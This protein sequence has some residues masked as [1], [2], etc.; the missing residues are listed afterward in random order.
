MSSGECLP[1]PGKPKAVTRTW[2]VIAPCSPLSP[3]DISPVSTA[4]SKLKTASLLDLDPDDFMAGLVDAGLEDD[5]SDGNE[6]EH[7]DDD[8]D[9]EKGEDQGNDSA[10][11]R[12]SLVLV[13]AKRM[14][15][16]T[17]VDKIFSA[18]VSFS[19]TAGPVSH[20]NPTST[21]SAIFY[22]H[23]PVTCAVSNVPPDASILEESLR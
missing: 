8:E 14:I 17:D 5:V 10:F 18:C 20:G 11:T 2:Q 15:R 13:V 23:L 3:P 4:S 21:E 1:K 9:K 6:E 19:R 7:D 12:L 22:E 16:F